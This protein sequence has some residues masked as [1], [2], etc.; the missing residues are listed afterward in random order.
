MNV[1]SDNVNLNTRF[2]AGSHRILDEGRISLGTFSGYLGNNKLVVLID[3]DISGIPSA[4]WLRFE[5]YVFI[6]GYDMCPVVKNAYSVVNL[7]ATATAAA[8][9]AADPTSH[10][11]ESTTVKGVTV[12][13]QIERL[14]ERNEI[15]FIALGISFGIIVILILI[16]IVIS[17]HYKK[18]KL[19]RTHVSEEQ[20]S[21]APVHDSALTSQKMPPPLSK[22]KSFTCLAK[23]ENKH[24]LSRS[25][26]AGHVSRMEAVTPEEKDAELRLTLKL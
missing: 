26:S 16:I 7:T 19:N 8:T 18:R 2:E 11:P 20:P 24:Q 17:V 12:N 25:H 9:A 23:K 13:S 6:G 5:L 15:L 14:E 4:E 10:A 22:S 21:P 1:A 3:V